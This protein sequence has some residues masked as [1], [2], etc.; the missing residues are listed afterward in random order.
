MVRLHRIPASIILDREFSQANFRGSYFIGKNLTPFS[1]SYHSE[2]DG[3]TEVVNRSLEAY[4][5]CFVEAT[6][7]K[8]SL[9]LH[10]AEVVNRSLEY[11]DIS[12]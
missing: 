2:T 6:P 7:K 4:L 11:S 1:S 3:Q 5:H 8:W 10:W 9:M 12:E